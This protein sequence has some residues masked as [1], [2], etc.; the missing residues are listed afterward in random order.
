MVMEDEQ[1]I[2]GEIIA[3]HTR[4]YRILVERYQNPVFRV[5][6]KIVGDAE[7]AKELTQ[8]VFVKAF[9]SIAQ[10]KPEHKFFSWI[11]RIAINRALL[12]VKRKKNFMQIEN[13]PDQFYQVPDQPFEQENRDHLL[14]GSI[15]ELGEHYKSVVLLKYY[16]DLSYAD[17]ADTLG[18]PEK[19]VKSR[20]FDARKILKEKLSK[21]DFF[22]SVQTN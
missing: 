22:S 12:F 10:Y 18:I 8:D 16:A 2:I 17:I 1:K 9:E 19:T 6:I 13:V 14:N 3:G 20:L 15:N 21:T 4:Q 7:D 11:Y 5:I